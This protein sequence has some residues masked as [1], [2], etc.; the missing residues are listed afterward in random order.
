MNQ[1]KIGKFIAVLRKQKDL[2]QE[3]LAEQLGISDRAVSKWER[4]LNLP[5]ASL[6]L[7]LSNILDISV[8]ELLS[9]EKIEEK[10]Y[11]NKAE[12]NLSYLKEKNDEYAKKLL[13]FE[14]IIGFICSSLFI[15][16]IFIA[17]YIEMNSVIR[18]VLIVIGFSL[19]IVGIF[20]CIK[21][22]QIAGYYECQK[23]KYK[24]IP[25]FNQILFSLHIG[26]S[27]K[28]KCPKCLKKSYHKKVISK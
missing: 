13:Y 16:L 25:T 8:N 26:R 17:S 18:I 10:E 6:M 27:R 7:K 12:E 5:D 21:I 1:E 15:I 11:K 23:C 3:E 22:E 9:G 14:C 2:T 4:G 28:F 24:Y 20:N 19:F